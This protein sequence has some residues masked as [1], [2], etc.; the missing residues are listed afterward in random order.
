MQDVRKGLEVQTEGFSH[1]KKTIYMQKNG[2]GHL[3]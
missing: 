2:V 3:N 1:K